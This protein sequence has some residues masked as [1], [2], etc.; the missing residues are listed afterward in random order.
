MVGINS[1]ARAQ[2]LLLSVFNSQLNWHIAAGQSLPPLPL[3]NCLA[4]G[5]HSNLQLEAI[6]LSIRPNTSRGTM[7]GMNIQDGHARGGRCC[8]CE[9]GKTGG[10]R[11]LVAAISTDTCGRLLSAFSCL[12]YEELGLEQL[13]NI[14]EFRD[15]PGN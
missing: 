15:W 8:E 12:P 9:D 3:Q 10:H 1:C 7:V 4:K 5:A 6:I 11:K 2:T 13:A 14:L